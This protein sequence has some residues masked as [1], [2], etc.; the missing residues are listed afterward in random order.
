MNI[1][2]T[3]SFSGQCRRRNFFSKKKKITFNTI[4]LD[5]QLLIIKFLDFEGLLQTPNL[6][7]AQRKITRHPN[8][9]L[10]VK[11]YEQ[12]VGNLKS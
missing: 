11:H 5:L 1:L 4:P 9:A 3:Y 6:N 12:R 7:K 8:F 2:S 10:D